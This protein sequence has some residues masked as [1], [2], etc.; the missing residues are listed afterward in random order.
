VNVSCMI[1]NKGGKALHAWHSAPERAGG[2]LRRVQRRAGGEGRRGERGR[3]R[4]GEGLRRAG[5]AVSRGA[6]AGA[7][8]RRIQPVRPPRRTSGRSSEREGFQTDISGF[9]SGYRESFGATVQGQ[10][11]EQGQTRPP[12]RVRP[13]RQ[14]RAGNRLIGWHEACGHACDE[15][16]RGRVCH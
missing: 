1:Q 15:S 14:A 11:Q 9:G 10:G 8:R 3:P 7:Q 5:R 16:S 12:W 4:G 13:R 6:T 2:E